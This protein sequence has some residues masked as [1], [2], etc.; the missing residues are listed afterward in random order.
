[1]KYTTMKLGQILVNSGVLSQQTL[2]K[3][4]SEQKGTTKRLG[5]ILIENKHITER[6][7]IDS[8][9]HQLDIPYLDLDGM[10]V[11]E[12]IAAIIPETMARINSLIPVR[13]EGNVLTVAIADPLDYNVIRNVEVYTGHMANVVIAEKKKILDQI[14]QAY[15]SQKAFDAA[16]ELSK[17]A[18]EDELEEFPEES[19][20]PII[21]FVNNMIDQAVILKAS[22]IH[23]EPQEKALR[24]RFRIDGK[25]TVYME[26]GA[27]L[28][29]P[30]VSR[31]KFI[32]NMNIAEKR[33][34]QD[35]RISYKSAGKDVDLRISVLPSVFGEKVVIRITTA[36]GL[37]MTKEGIGFLPENLEKFNS[38]IKNPHGIILVCGP[39]GSGK[40]TTLY[41]ALREIKREDINIVTV[42]NPV[43]MIIEGITQVEVNAKAGLTF[44]AA[45]RSI[46]RQ[47]PDV[48]MVGEIR[49]PET[50]EIAISAAITGH[51]V[52]ST[53]H[54]FDAPSAIIRLLDMGVVPYMVSSSVAGVISQRLVRKLCPVCKEAYEAMESDRKLLGLSEGQTPVTLY[55]PAG[56]E[57]CHFTGYQ[58]RTAVHEVM[59]INHGIRHIINQSK[60]ADEI[61]EEALKGGMQTL[62]DNVRRLVLEGNTSISEYVE[63]LSFN[64]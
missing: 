15:T 4:L 48:V 50:A 56:C 6:Q 27:D 24:I 47:D 41:T 16:R 36:L 59:M 57:K 1:M 8:L 52:F 19:D 30:V 28:I 23:I 29:A 49:D 32:S 54:T 5:E 14:H 38:L 42:E 61:R 21:R 13:L 11:D 3:A 33:V 35:G 63:L 37:E 10:T 62:E 58:G 9:S 2:E 34:P 46:L 20:E 64:A 43:E 17:D 44:A 40:T 25:L 39:T 60:G 55:Q 53:L 18:E 31:I 22:D 12:T 51:L 26:T 45:L 7:L